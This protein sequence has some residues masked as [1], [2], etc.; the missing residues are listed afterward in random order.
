MIK[1]A[2]FMG[3]IK[4]ATTNI[5]ADINVLFD[6]NREI[7]RDTNKLNREVS[8]IKLKLFGIGLVGGAMFEFG[9]TLV[10]KWI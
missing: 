3:Q 4:E 10:K 6:Q 7:I 2:T 9:I 1:V 8:S 5:K